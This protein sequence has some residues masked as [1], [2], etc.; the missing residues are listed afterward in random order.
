MNSTLY[1][2]AMQADSVLGRVG[3]TIDWKATLPAG[4]PE[5]W[6]TYPHPPLASDWRTFLAQ[7][8]QIVARNAVRPFHMYF[9]YQC[10]IIFLSSEACLLADPHLDGSVSDLRSVHLVFG[11]RVRD[12]KIGRLRLHLEWYKSDN[13]SLISENCVFKRVKS[14]EYDIHGTRVGRGNET[15]Q[16]CPEPLE[17]GL[18]FG[19]DQALRAVPYV[20]LSKLKP[21]RLCLDL[22]LPPVVFAFGQ[23]VYVRHDMAFQL[24]ALKDAGVHFPYAAIEVLNGSA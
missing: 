18:V 16:D 10:N 6:S 14:M 20:S 11:K 4:L 17:T 9:N 7:T 3:F 13:H 23:S 5:D 2:E 22:Q 24:A 1:V 19:S 12:Y 21:T 15:S 8:D